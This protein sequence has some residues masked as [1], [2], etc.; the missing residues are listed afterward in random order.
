MHISK[1]FREELLSLFMKTQLDERLLNAPQQSNLCETLHFP[2]VRFCH[3]FSKSLQFEIYVKLQLDMSS[4]SPY[5][6][7]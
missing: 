2:R 4:S 5:L 1:G 6:N 7:D 3:P